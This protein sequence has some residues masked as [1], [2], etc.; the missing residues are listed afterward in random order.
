MP[1]PTVNDVQP[2]NPVLTNMML[3]YQ[4]SDDRFVASRAFPA[5]SVD[6]DSGT[7]MIFDKKYWFVDGLVARAPGAPFARTGFG[8]SSAIYTTK[9]WAISEALA[10]EIRANSQAPMDL[11]AATLQ[12]IAQLSLIRKERAFAA[13]FMTTSVWAT[14]DNNSATDWD[15]FSAGDPVSNIQTAVRTISNSTGQLAN[16][17]VCG[18]IVA[19]ALENH[20]DIL[21]RMKYVQAATQQNVRAV[22]AS[23]LGLENLLV[24][25]ASYNSANVGQAVSQAAIIDDDALIMYVNPAAGVFGATA[26]KTFAWEPGGG[27]GGVRMYRDE[28][29]DADVIKHKE[30]WDQKAVATDCG[31]FFAD[32][33]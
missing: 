9:Q 23:V 12:H 18:F 30:Q 15:D 25:L 19:Q 27:L 24:S 1:L 4:Q 14:D 13:D 16:T 32:I 3:G 22:M 6:K 11:E 7:Y 29:S 2:V 33:V 10:D 8:A 28:G 21:D 17:M 20:P 5:V 31:Y 26:G